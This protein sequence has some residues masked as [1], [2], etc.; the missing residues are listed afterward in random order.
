M[1]VDAATLRALFDSLGAGMYAVD[2]NG[3]VTAANPMSVQ[4]L[5][6]TA[7]DLVGRSVHDVLHARR[8]EERADPAPDCS[9]RRAVHCGEPVRVDNDVFC[10][11]DGGL[12][13]VSW[14]SAPQ[15]SDGT[16][17]GAVLVFFDESRRRSQDEERA[18]QLRRERAART[19]AERAFARLTLVA[20][21]SEALTATLDV[22]EA[23]RR[24]ANLVVPDVADWC[25]VDLYRP[26]TDVERVIVAHRDPTRAP[27]GKYDGAL[28]ALQDESRSPLARVLRGASPILLTDIA[29]PH[30]AALPLD[31]EEL[32][33]F[34]E[35]EADTAIVAPLRARR[36]VLGAITFVRTDPARALTAVDVALAAD[37][38]RRAGLA[39]DNA[40]L[41]S[42]QRNAVAALQRSLLGVPPPI[43]GV[44]VAVRYQPASETAE[45]G[46]DWYDCFLLPDGPLCVA[47]GD[48]VGHDIEAAARMAQLRSILRG[49][50]LDS[51]QGPAYVL[52]QVDAIMQHLDLA[53]LATGVLA[54]VQP[55][56]DGWR[57]RW[58][59]AGH[60]PP[61]LVLPDGGTEVLD[62]GTGLLL[63]VAIET[64]RAEEER[65]VLPGTTLLL[66]TDGLVESRSQSIELGLGRLR[67]A[68]GA[69]AR[70]P[71][72]SFADRLLE[73]LV[74][75]GTTD[76]V[77][78]IA[79]RLL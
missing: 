65:D 53:E 33:L 48:V 9:L 4:L 71:L 59:N 74:G 79:V 61:I 12:L 29:A 77:A 21:I 24:L 52:T 35:L 38:G 46:G 14:T 69:L 57:L 47:I 55:G 64:S 3:V 56:D 76:D 10:R 32:E 1:A 51:S 26:P 15:R 39:V 62:G 60:P 73:R 7:T 19:E 49:V 67:R 22:R 28:P 66:Y 25:V 75:S 34:A 58:A 40:R 36:Q 41:Y 6:Y 20:A 43:P 50:A 11:A 13:P 68:A 23:L 72:E 44:E 37:I 30:T 17:T 8:D 45:I 2:A 42:E 70:E 63:G 54:Q 31:R 27:P 18:E 16:P 78:L 5:G